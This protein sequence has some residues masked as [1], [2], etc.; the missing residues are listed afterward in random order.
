[1]PIVASMQM[2]QLEARER[3]LRDKE[4]RVEQQVAQQEA[5]VASTSEKHKQKSS[6]C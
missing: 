6:Y 2:E 4:S 1:M 5:L 3:L